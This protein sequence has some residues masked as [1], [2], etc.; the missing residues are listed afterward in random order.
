MEAGFAELTRLV[1]TGC[2]QAVAAL[3]AAAARGGS[4]DELTGLLRVAFCQRNQLDAALSGVIAE[5][6]R[7]AAA[8]GPDGEATSGLSCASWLAHTLHINPGAAHAQVRLA[9]QLPSLP[10][11]A[12]AFER[13][14]LSA[15]HASVVA[16]SVE[17]VRRG[18]G[19][20]ELAEDL[21]LR[22]AEQRDP[23]DLFRWG[24][25][26]VHRLA[27]AEMEA[28][29]ERRRQRRSL[30]LVEVFSGGYEVSG[31]LDPVGG[32]TLKTALD[33]LMGP[34]ARDD[35]RTPDQR[36]ADAL[37]ELAGRVLDSG[38]LPV[39]G[40]QRPHLTVTATHVTKN[41]IVAS[42]LNSPRS[43][44][45]PPPIPASRCRRPN[46]WPRSWPASSGSIS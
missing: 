19:D 24:L 33:G 14:E 27:P 34:R 7:A 45:R 22:E 40:G 44:R 5:L 8:A 12:E 38:G 29:E 11:T 16:R 17:Q 4:V 20:V 30:R 32:A 3:R 42:W 2:Q 9:R 36:R 39:R 13:G 35:E 10:A 23:R 15:Q 43:P 41:T 1:E 37:V 18:G 46:S 26:L 28:D 6:D 31:Y 25:S 21:L